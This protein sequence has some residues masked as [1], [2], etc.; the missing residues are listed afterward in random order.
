MCRGCARAWGAWCRGLAV[1][2]KLDKDERRGMVVCR[3]GHLIEEAEYGCCGEQSRLEDG[4]LV[5]Q[6]GDE[7]LEAFSLVSVG[8]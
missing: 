4:V 6:R 8:C 2:G 5:V 7:D 3:T 1:R